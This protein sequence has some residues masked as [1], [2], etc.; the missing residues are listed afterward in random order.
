VYLYIRS[1]INFHG[2]VLNFS[3][4]GTILPHNVREI[5]T[6]FRL[7]LLLLYWRYNPIWVLNSSMVSQQYIFLVLSR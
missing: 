4:T 1:P 7:L 6:F 3:R 2:V 5:R